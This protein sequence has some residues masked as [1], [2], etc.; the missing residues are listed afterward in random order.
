M[1]KFSL[2]I[3]S[4][5]FFFAYLGFVIVNNTSTGHVKRRKVYD[6]T[7]LFHLKWT[8]LKTIFA[9]FLMELPITKE[10]RIMN[11]RTTKFI[12]RHIVKNHKYFMTILLFCIVQ[13]KF[14]INIQRQCE[15]IY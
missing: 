10:S 15:V 1:R 9:T 6:L 4:N 5:C 13:S 2:K 7:L 12:D 11:L 3:Y 8:N 14:Q